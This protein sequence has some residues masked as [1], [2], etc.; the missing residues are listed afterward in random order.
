MGYFN[1]GY[2]SDMR[3]DRHFL[4]D[5]FAGGLADRDAIAVRGAHHDAFHDRL[6]A[7]ERLLAAFQNGEHLYVRETGEEKCEWR[8]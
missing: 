6:A 1:H 5:D 8:E 3:D 2:F 4:G 7:D